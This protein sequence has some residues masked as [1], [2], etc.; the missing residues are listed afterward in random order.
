MTKR[1]MPDQPDDQRN[2][3]ERKPSGGRGARARALLALALIF[4]LGACS[5][6]SPVDSGR[7]GLFD[8][9]S[10]GSPR[11]GHGSRARPDAQAV[12]VARLK[13]TTSE[14]TWPLRAV[15][16]TSPFGTRGGEPHEGIDLRARRGTPVYAAHAGQVLYA[17]QK[18]RGYGKLVV[19]R[20]RSGLSTV[21][22][23]NSRLLVKAGQRVRQGQRI[24]LSGATGH[25]TAP[26]LHFEVRDGV[27]ALDPSA[28]MPPRAL[29]RAVPVSTP[30]R[31]PAPLVRPAARKVAASLSGS[32]GSR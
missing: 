2:Q 17:G 3:G 20:H 7:R 32:R 18:I 26:H 19:L 24:A 14:W 23:H 1:I 29:A 9:L 11:L 13:G 30:R 31:R 27:T 25:V 4:A 15:T 21:Y 6:I 16:V 22:A 12:R 5:S 10:D 8:E 28:L